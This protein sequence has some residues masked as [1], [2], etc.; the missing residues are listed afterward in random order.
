MNRRPPRRPQAPQ[1]PQSPR[2]GYW[3]NYYWRNHYPYNWYWHHDY[4][5]DY[6]WYDYDWYN[7]DD[8][9]YDYYYHFGR[10]DTS[11]EAFDRGFREGLKQAHK[12]TNESATAEQP[13]AGYCGS[14]GG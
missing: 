4:D 1:S 14:M 9:L 2:P 13:A 7:G 11:K 6:D 8:N 12:V 10:Y 3:N 5:Y